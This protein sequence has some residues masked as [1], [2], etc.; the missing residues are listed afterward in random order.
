[1]ALRTP[2]IASRSVPFLKL[3]RDYLKNVGTA[4]ENRVTSAPFYW[5]SARV[6]T[7]ASAAELHA[8]LF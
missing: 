7:C 2:P 6:E 4:Q 3:V 8:E 1:M 5:K